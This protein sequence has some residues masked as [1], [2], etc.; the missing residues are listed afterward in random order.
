MDLTEAKKANRPKR[1][2]RRGVKNTQN[3]QKSFHVPDNQD[4]VI[5]HRDQNILECEVKWASGNITMNKASG[6]DGIPGELFQTLKDDAALHMPA[7]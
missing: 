7:N 2:K 5:T 1:S 6:G 4:G 3:I